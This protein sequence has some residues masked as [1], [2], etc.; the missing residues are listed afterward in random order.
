MALSSLRFELILAITLLAFGMLVLPMAVYWVGQLA[1]GGYESDA[2]MDGLIA[3][4]WGD[5]G[6][7]GLAAW[8]LVL[9]PYAVIQ[10]L[11]GAV[12]LFRRP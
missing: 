7:G 12:R 3:A 5:L 11:R 9:S 8:L 1:I 2:G 4:L 10:L 6:R